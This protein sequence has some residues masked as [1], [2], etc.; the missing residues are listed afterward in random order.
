MQLAE[1]GD[2][3]PLIRTQAQR[4]LHTIDNVLLYKRFVAGQIHLQLEPVHVGSTIAQIANDVEPQMKMNGYRSQLVIGQSLGAVDVDRQL[5]RAALLS[6]WQA[7][8]SAAGKTSQIV[9]NAHRVG[10][11]VRVSLVGGEHQLERFSLAT[12]NM[13][14]RQPVRAVAGPAA[15]LLAARG[16]FDLIG[17]R[18][19]K[20]QRGGMSGFGVTLPLSRQ[21]HLV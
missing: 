1:L 8:I 18:L 16:M 7:Y 3:D 2:K 20:T 10:D 19:S 17:A 9:C 13:S 5:F 4:A 21:L 15:D 14:S 6:M 11:G 12:A